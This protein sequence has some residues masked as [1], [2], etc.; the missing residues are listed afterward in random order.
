M[1]FTQLWQIFIKPSYATH[2][3]SNQK[4]LK[5]VCYI[6]KDDLFT[7]ILQNVLFLFIGLRLKATYLHHNWFVA[8][9]YL[10]VTV[11]GPLHPLHS[12]SVGWESTLQGRMCSC[13]SKFFLLRVDPIEICSQRIKFF[14]LIVDPIK[15]VAKMKTKQCCFPWKMYWFTLS[16][17]AR[18]LTEIISLELFAFLL[19]AHCPEIFCYH[20]GKCNLQPFCTHKGQNPIECKRIKNIQTI[21]KQFPFC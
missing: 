21:Q 18:P 7:D 5:S 17:L 6:H 10:I 13:M 12:L 1:C 16:R 3:F 11:F 20:K 4:F 2:I 15:K 8:K 14:L 19:K 9:G